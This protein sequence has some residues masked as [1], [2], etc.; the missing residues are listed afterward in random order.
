MIHKFVALFRATR[1]AL[2]IGYG[3]T[4]AISF[5]WFS[6]DVRRRILQNWSTGL[7]AIF[8]VRVDIAADDALHGLHHGLIVTN[9]ISW[10]D[11]FV[12][13]A[14][15]PMRFVAKS[16]VRRWPVIGWL[17]AR[18]QTLFLERGKARDA[19]RMNVQLVSLLQSGE[20]LAVFPEGTTTDGSH[21]AHFHSSLLQPAIDA[22]AQVF[23]VAIRYQDESGMRSTAAAYIDE[24]SF[25][26][27]M[28]N[29][30]CT[31]EL[32]V[33]LMA[34]PS[35]QAVSMDRRALTR[36]AHKQISA[37]LATT[38]SHNF[39]IVLTPAQHTESNLLPSTR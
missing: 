35:L 15:V 14:V 24:L 13:N 28:W 3:L 17:C 18:A 25:G 10:L 20:C 22:G 7:L 4:L 8:N 21:V 26:A 30:L 29:I 34:T 23:P 1:L 27:S 2:H 19:A 9:H 36:A 39:H 33:R 32:H 5:P 38:D 11:V 37:A 31:P 16:E 12:L 6:R